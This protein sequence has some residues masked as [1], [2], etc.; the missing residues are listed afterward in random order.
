MND[1]P[2]PLLWPRYIEKKH[3][4]RVL[5]YFKDFLLVTEHGLRKE[6]FT[7]EEFY[8]AIFEH[9]V[10]TFVE[11][12]PFFP[13]LEEAIQRGVQ[14][15]CTKEGRV[16]SMFFRGPRNTTRWIVSC[17]SWGYQ[18]CS[19]L[20][21]EELRATYDYCGV[22]TPN[23]A[24]SLGLKLMREAWKRQYGLPQYDELGEC[25]DRGWKAHRHQ[26]PNKLACRT[27]QE[28]SSGARSETLD[29]E[30]DHPLAYEIDEKNGYAAAFIKEGQPTG[31]CFRIVAGPSP[32]MLKWFV[33]CTITIHKPLMLGPFPVRLQ[34]RPFY[35]T[36]PGTYEGWLWNNEIKL[37]RMSGCTV[38]EHEGYGWKEV[39][40]DMNCWVQLMSWLRDNAPSK[41]V[42]QHVKLAIVAGIGRFNMADES[43]TL[44]P[45]EQ[46]KPGIDRLAQGEAGIALSWFIH[47]SVEARP[48]TMPHWFSHTLA[49]AREM[50]YKEMLPHA[51]KEMIISSNTDGFIVK[52][53]ADISH[54]PEKG[55]PGLATGT[56]SVRTLLNVRTPAARHLEAIDARTGERISKRPGIP[57]KGRV[58]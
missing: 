36:Q 45:E 20:M 7:L 15:Y 51:E 8:V 43:Y 22:G 11:S 19:P 12:L 28:K 49:V 41:A 57:R 16:V 47:A 54:Y 13:F 50:L 52:P 5:A 27:I 35:P 26:R 14:P 3:T 4:Q 1:F 34:D 38:V 2:M 56:F 21:L 42:E 46:A 29:T 44:I 17:K 39:T 10:L 24:G 9:N 53:E 33:R 23:T 48:Q 58:E 30:A 37:A 18:A 31:Q 32:S 25:V 55:T 40:R 6:I